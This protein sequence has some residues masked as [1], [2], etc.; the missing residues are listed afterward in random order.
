MAK[1][2]ALIFLLKDW[3]WLKHCKQKL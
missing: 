2:N 1:I 3:R